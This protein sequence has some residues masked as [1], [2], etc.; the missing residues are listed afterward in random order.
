MKKHLLLIF[1][2]L[3]LPTTVFATAQ[4]PD[5]LFYNGER[6][7]IFSNPLESYFD[8]DHPRPKGLFKF[9]CTA[10]WRGYVAT[11]KI[12]KGF[13]YLVRI[14]EG[15]CASD[16]PEISLDK[17]FPDRPPPI[18]AVWFSGVLRI[19]RGKQLRYVHMG[20]RSVYEKEW[21][22]TLK[23]GKIV[24]EEVIDHTQH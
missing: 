18:K 22:L 17:I 24:G 13:L 10:V 11:W 19:P 12:E 21:A 3:F 15:T 2:L 9:T 23:D 8:K 1:S 16:A 14:V 5:V 6:L 4:F 7:E 20:Y